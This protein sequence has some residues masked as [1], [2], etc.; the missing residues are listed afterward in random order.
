MYNYKAKGNST[1]KAASH[2]K[3]KKKPVREWKT[4]KQQQ[5]KCII[6]FS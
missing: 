1:A 6:Q 3:G 5:G 2:R 4:C